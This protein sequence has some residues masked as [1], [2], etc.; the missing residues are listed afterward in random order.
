MPDLQPLNADN[1][2]PGD[3]PL[4]T[5][6]YDSCKVIVS[7]KDVASGDN[8]QEHDKSPKI[9]VVAG[10]T[11]GVILLVVLGLI[12]TQFY[13]LLMGGA[14]ILL[15]IVARSQRYKPKS[16]V[17]YQPKLSF[18]EK[19]IGQ[20]IIQIVTIILIIYVA[21]FLLAF[22]ACVLNFTS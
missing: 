1:S 22:G 11:I 7:S 16:D 13:M 12:F 5:D 14:V 4:A 21:Y 6:P 2:T 3:A 9:S 19:S 17:R 20:K 18:R 8:I 10:G 15:I